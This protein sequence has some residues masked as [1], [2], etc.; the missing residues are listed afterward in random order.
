M[1]TRPLSETVRSFESGTTE[2][3][4]HTLDSNE[5]NLAELP[6]VEHVTGRNKDLFGF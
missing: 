4:D 2:G 1:R 6:I 5:P 3:E